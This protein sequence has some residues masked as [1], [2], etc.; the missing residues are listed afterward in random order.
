MNSATNKPKVLLEKL[1]QDA[2][3]T[4]MS[5]KTVTERLME[6]GAAC[7]ARRLCLR[8]KYASE[9]Y[10]WG[11]AMNIAK[12]QN[13]NEGEIASGVNYELLGEVQ[14]RKPL[15]HELIAAFERLAQ[16]LWGND[17][18]NH[19]A[20]T[21]ERN[22]V[23]TQ[24]GESLAALALVGNPTL[25][26]VFIDLD[27]FKDLNSH[28]T[29]SG[30]DKVIQTINRQFHDM[31]R[32]FGGLAFNRSGDEF[33]IFLP[34]DGLL[35][36]LAA[37]YKM[38]VAVK[39]Q[40]YK[41]ASGVEVRVDMT[42]G[43]VPSKEYSTH[44]DVV[45]ATS[46]AEALTKEK[47]VKR[48]GRI[49]IAVEQAARSKDCTP[50]QLLKIGAALVRRRLHCPP[51]GS[52][53]LN[54]VSQQ[55][56][57]AMIDTDIDLNQT[58]ND[59]LAWLDL[60]MDSKSWESSLL[61]STEVV[62]VPRLAVALAV[63][64]GFARNDSS[65]SS[66]VTA[67]RNMSIAY[68]E[69]GSRAAVN[70]DGKLVWG[71]TETGDTAFEVLVPVNGNNR[72]VCLVGVQVGLTEYPISDTG[73]RLPVDLFDQI[74]LVDD[75]PITGGSLPDFWQPAIAEVF[76]TLGRQDTEP[77]VIV[78]GAL[79]VNSETYKKLAGSSS[80]NV[81]EVASVSQLSA[82]TVES[83]RKTVEISIT[84]VSDGESLSDAVFAATP[85]WPRKDAGSQKSHTSDQ[86]QEKLTRPM[87][88]PDSLPLEDGVRCQNAAQAY[89][90]IIDVLRKGKTVRISTD[91]AK[92]RLKELLAFKLIL[93]E[94]LRNAVPAYLE[95]LRVDLDAYTQR[96]MLDKEN[97]L[98]RK[99]LESTRQ[100]DAFVNHLSSYLGAPEPARSTRRASLVVPNVIDDNGEL[101]PLGLLN[102]WASPRVGEDRHVIDFV[103]VW[104]TVEAFVGLPYS[105]YG[106]IRLA[107]DLVKQVSLIVPIVPNGRAAAVGELTY[108]PMS[109]HMR[110]D[111]FHDRIAK[112]IV[113]ESSD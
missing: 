9:E 47:G 43:V 7:F 74:V 25:A 13:I 22:V 2:R 64:H 111:E 67:S 68:A 52:A 3:S 76:S 106:S 63:A 87:L 73:Q 69:D 65:L 59:A 85:T 82:S 26:V 75:R 57:S 14:P 62:T 110:V 79:A 10:L 54:F 109:L 28:I 93:E 56:A 20:I 94:P 50:L 34:F 49:T 40:V 17:I 108:I 91:D 42:M 16:A 58:V 89:P 107:E 86:W 21:F 48:R 51:F 78:W 105:L 6:I 1:E 36:I 8:V 88:S 44:T 77:H 90:I 101:K 41:G 102:V 97:G 84:L 112:R 113:D 32:E 60:S 103:F 98:F 95:E 18:R 4:L 11:D 33:F 29:E 39:A 38:R 104:R 83:L 72:E 27:H 23:K 70:C 30:A 12:L 96:A 53:K 15:D 55:T 100:A 45:N 46:A 92:G 31:T 81:D 80:W 19:G 35:P 24:I 99:L 5:P 66:S 37:L 71:S 61:A